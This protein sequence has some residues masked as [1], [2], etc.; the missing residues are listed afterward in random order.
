M[1]KFHNGE[2][3]YL[4]SVD[5]LNEGIDFPF[6]E[7]VAFLRATDSKRIFFQQL[8]RGARPDKDKLIVLDFVANVD[9][10]LMIREMMQRVREEVEAN[11]D[12]KGKLS[13][14]DFNVSG[15]GFE[16]V[17]SD[18]L[19]DLLTVI[20][21][22]KNGFYETYEEASKAAQ[23]LGVKTQKEY[24]LRYRE[25]LRLPYSPQE[26]YEAD[27]VS[28]KHFLTGEDLGF[29]ETYEEASKAAQALKV[30]GRRGY[31]ASYKKDSRLP[32]TPHRIYKEDWVS[33]FHFLGQKEK[34]FYRTLKEAKF[35]VQNL[36]ISSPKEYNLRYKE[37]PKLPSEPW[38]MYEE[39]WVSS[40][41]FFG[42]KS[43]EFYE[44]YEEASKAA[45]KL[46]V[47]TSKE[48]WANYRKDPKLRRRPGENWKDDWIS[49]SH[50]LG[51]D[52]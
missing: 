44:T 45:R 49:W 15:E 2:I 48:Y 28:L 27:W 37:D 34:V 10:L 19:V 23:K 46:G 7:L 4:I 50:F 14:R 32:G 30:K 22:L 40:D 26:V 12:L 29:Y 11:E 24:C 47:K 39:D 3:Q 36:N 9:R 41:D 21:V 5:K 43:R 52:K 33:W 31:D 20:D 6:V 8:G 17:F 1:K 35:A 42:R 16:F 38:A 13:V 51:T 25:D 18:E